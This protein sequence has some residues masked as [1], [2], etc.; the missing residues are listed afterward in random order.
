[1]GTKTT[2]NLNDLII[3]V[4]TIVTMLFV[5]VFPQ[6]ASA[7]N[8]TA[9]CFVN[10][11]AIK[12]GE[13]AVWTVEAEGGSGNYSY[14]WT[15]TD[16]LIGNNRRVAKIYSRPGTVEATVTV[17][18]AEQSVTPS[19]NLIVL[20]TFQTLTGSCFAQS[21]ILRESDRVD[22][23]VEAAGGDGRYDF[24]WSGTDDLRGSGSG[25]SRVYNFPG[26]KDATVVITSDGHSTVRECSVTIEP[27]PELEGECYADS[28]SINSGEAVTW[29]ALASGGT[30]EYRYSWF[31]DNLRGNSQAVSEIYDRTG[32]R[33]ANVEITSGSQS[34]LRICSVGVKSGGEVLGAF[35]ED[36]IPS[37]SPSVVVE[38]ETPKNDAEF[39]FIGW[40]I[41]STLVVLI[42][43]A[44]LS[45]MIVYFKKQARA[46]EE[47]EG[48]FEKGPEKDIADII[49]SEAQK[50]E[51]VISAEAILLL[52]EK[53]HNSITEGV[54]QLHNIIDELKKTTETI[55]VDGLS[56]PAS[57]AV[58][59]DESRWLVIDEDMVEKHFSGHK[60]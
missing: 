2:Q 54:I 16:N 49:Q 11:I 24:A 15:G 32:E 22:W 31:G 59:A 26:H 10:P 5:I 27:D 30:G 36:Q 33:T 7:Q 51:V 57:M 50:R 12:V 39:S 46:E 28:D 17:Y 14:F 29:T 42:G 41:L 13:T 48:V 37:V 23:R 38:E 20:E 9:S 21:S 34:I 19:C 35:S 43:A 60:G 58:P 44:I 45:G 55:V 8:L 3:Q 56:N 4:A 40:K 25:I 6:V 47:K 52:M 53:T 1:M 18:S